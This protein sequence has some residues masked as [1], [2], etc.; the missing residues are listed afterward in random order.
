MNISY[1]ANA[2]VDSI[3]VLSDYYRK[4]PFIKRLFDSDVE[5]NKLLAST[6][7]LVISLIHT[8]E[9]AEGAEE[10][11]LDLVSEYI[12]RGF[13][14]VSVINCIDK[15][16]NEVLHRLPNITVD[17]R[18]NILSVFE[19]IK[20]HVSQGYIIKELT[21]LNI[22][23]F[24]SFSN[25]KIYINLTKWMYKFRELTISKSYEQ[26]LLFAS[27]PCYLQNS[28][29]SLTYKIRCVNHILCSNL[30]RS[31][32]EFHN[33]AK[34]FVFA[35]HRRNFITAYFLLIDLKNRLNEFVRN[36]E[37]TLII[38][39]DDAEN[40]LFKFISDIVK[41]P[42][43]KTLL[44]I[45]FKNL[46]ILSSVY[47]RDEIDEI[48]NKLLSV[49]ENFS[50]KMERTVVVKGSGKDIFVFA[51]NPPEKVVP[52][53]KLKLEDFHQYVSRKFK[54]IKPDIVTAGFR[55][56]P[57]IDIS[58]DEI[59]KS[60]YHLKLKAINEGIDECILGKR[61]R[62]SLIKEINKKYRDIQLINKL[63]HEGKVD[64]YFQPI[65]NYDSDKYVFYCLE[66]LA[67]MVVDGRYIP[68]GVFIDLIHEMDLIERL[69]EIVLEKLSYYA[70]YISK[71]TRK[72]SINASPH[73]M[74][75]EAFREKL[76]K[77]CED[78]SIN[79]ICPIIEITEQSLLESVDIIEEIGSMCGVKF[80]VDDF[81]VGYS[82]L[83]LV[84]DVAEKGLLDMLKIDGTL[85][86]KLKESETVAKIVKIVVNIA[87]ELEVRCVAEFVEDEET[88][89]ML[90]SMGVKL[91]QGY[92]LGLPQHL[93]TILANKIT[94]EAN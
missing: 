54:D 83:K 22:S 23:P 56:E 8:K 79:G 33:T 76:V 35:M 5:I 31:H 48:F 45:G 89:N 75:F 85:I 13:P 30:E 64:L 25:D 21:T 57:Y 61:K 16:K 52:E 70:K 66:S 69:D 15:L 51:L 73:S 80:G 24:E 41:G 2:V 32:R 4:D 71:V 49:L 88:L 87:N 78:L 91:F 84:A 28:F 86:K 46:L 81:G 68:A 39:R 90:H 26:A 74:Q 93:T 92:Y 14:Y 19:F 82:S 94:S 42:G 6:E 63:L 1:L 65:F 7:Q 62:I 60:I 37:G 40:I 36:I 58:E 38:F 44:I 3:T 67:R 43:E 47:S 11:T 18:D 72:V 29:K 59:R 53:L 10:M 9:G 34:D 55:L 27:E 12:E 17:E 20:N 77:T 50:D